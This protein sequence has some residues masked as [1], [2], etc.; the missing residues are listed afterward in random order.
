MNSVE[1]DQLVAQI[2]D[3]IL[4]RVNRPA[5]SRAEGLNIPDQVCPGCTQR[6]AQTC[7]AKTKQIVAMGADRVSASEKLTRVDPAIAKLIVTM[8]TPVEPLIGK[9]NNPCACRAPIM[10]INMPAAARVINSQELSLWLSVILLSV[11]RLRG[12]DAA[13]QN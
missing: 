3:E 13:K 1:L 9:R 7:A 12:L 8:P 10:I 6:C 5:L 2:G 4:A 11:A